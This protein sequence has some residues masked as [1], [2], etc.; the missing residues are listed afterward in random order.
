MPLRL[1]RHRLLSPLSI[2]AAAMT[3]HFFILMIHTLFRRHTPSLLIAISPLFTLPLSFTPY[4]PRRHYAIT[5]RHYFHAAIIAHHLINTPL[6]HY[7]IT[8]LASLLVITFWLIP[9]PFYH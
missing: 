5:L 4:S 6:R 3:F 1:R 9:L 8:L 2:D 7:A